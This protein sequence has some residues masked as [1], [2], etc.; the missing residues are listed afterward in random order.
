MTMKEEE[1]ETAEGEEVSADVEP[2]QTPSKQSPSALEETSTNRAEMAA[3]PEGD[4][5]PKRTAEAQAL[6]GNHGW[7]TTQGSK[8]AKR[9][10][11]EKER[12]P[13][14]KRRGPL[15]RP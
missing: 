15:E 7:R 11:V 6:E 2:K 14:A 1:E 13:E 4:P 12:S 3:T 5:H 9:S 8:A 10:T